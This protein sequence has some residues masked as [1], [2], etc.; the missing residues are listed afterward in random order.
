MP[1]LSEDSAVLPVESQNQPRNGKLPPP[2]ESLVDGQKA[3]SKKCQKC[4]IEK[5]IVEFHRDAGKRF[6]VR[7]DC[8]KCACAQKVIEHREWRLKNPAKREIY[9]KVARGERPPSKLLKRD[10]EDIDWAEVVRNYP[11][12][13]RSDSRDFITVSFGWNAMVLRNSKALA[14][15]FGFILAANLDL[16]WTI[17]YIRRIKDDPEL[18]AKQKERNNRPDIVVKR[19]AMHAEKRSD[20]EYVEKER[21]RGRE[22]FRNN[23][24]KFYAYRKEQRRTNPQYK[25]ACNLRTYIYQRIGGKIDNGRSRFRDIVG[26][27]IEELK[28]HLE[29]HFQPGMTWGNY[30]KLDGK[31]SIDHTRPCASYDLSKEDQQKE[32]F[33]FSNLRPM[34]WRENLMKSDKLPETLTAQA[35][36]A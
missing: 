10:V 7:N 31:W 35:V 2:T 26:C 25:I 20:P 32:C 23:K 5:L 18:K 33:N 19:A 6:G 8:K 13:K 29:A 11:N 28:A 4:G 30:G 15:L 16:F 36:L 3:L 17:Q 12:E 9:N 27:E 21:K 14:F 24:E 34:W 22:F 1:L